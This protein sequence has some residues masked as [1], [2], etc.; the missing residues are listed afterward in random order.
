V[1]AINA[2][3]DSEDEKHTAGGEGSEEKAKGSTNLSKAEEEEQL[4]AANFHREKLSQYNLRRKREK[5][6]RSSLKNDDKRVSPPLRNLD[7]T[8]RKQC[9]KR[10]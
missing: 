1:T 7:E 8:S 10:L 6:K 5:S 2:E 3:T 9:R 4:L